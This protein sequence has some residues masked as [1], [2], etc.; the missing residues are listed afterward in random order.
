MTLLT[1][2]ILLVT[3]TFFYFVPITGQPEVTILLSISTF[4]FTIFAGFFISRQGKRHSSIRKQITTFDGHMSAMY[5]NFGYLS[6]TSQKEAQQIIKKHYTTILKNKAWDWHFLNKSNTI[7][8]IHLILSES[9]LKKKL[10]GAQNFAL[11]QIM[12]SL[13]ELQLVR[14]NMVG[15]HQE[16]IPV[17]EWILLILLATT[18][19]VSISFIPSAELVI[20]ASLKGIF[21]TAV[22]IVL[23]MLHELDKLRLFETTLGEQSAKDILDIFKGKK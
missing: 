13:R 14:K 9:F 5:R 21:S 7:T 6:L 19:I 16:R 12:V 18:I 23:V 15:L 8:N 2:L 1:I 11:L 4:T 17:F 22:I 20:N 10:A 3:S